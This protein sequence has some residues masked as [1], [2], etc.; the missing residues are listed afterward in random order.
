VT[1]ITESGFIDR[2]FAQLASGQ[3]IPQMLRADETKA[4]HRVVL[5]GDEPWFSSDEWSP[6][7]VVSIDRRRVRLILIEAKKPGAG[8]FTRLTA[9]ILASGLKPMV[10]APTREFQAM[11]ARR[12]WRRKDFGTGLRHEERWEPFR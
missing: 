7:C 9:R 3:T 4:G 1:T 11:L 6:D 8:S 2:M 10:L 5:P 12:G